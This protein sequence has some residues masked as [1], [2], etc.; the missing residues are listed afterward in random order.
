MLHNSILKLINKG[1]VIMA[2]PIEGMMQTAMQSIKEMVDV[3]TIV[4]NPVNTPDGTVIIPI[5][6]VSFGFAAGGSEFGKN[7]S[8]DAMFG[9][10]SGGGVSISPVAFMVVGQNQI[11]LLPVS[12]SDSPVERILDAV[13]GVIDKI[14][15]KL[16]KKKPEKENKKEADVVKDA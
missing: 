1:G 7:G 15:G 3:E 14:N 6:K 9:G 5:S 11:K 16:N 4:G 12:V 10:G 13:P 2:H 8:E